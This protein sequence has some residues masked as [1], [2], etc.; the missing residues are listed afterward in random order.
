MYIASAV[1]MPTK[2]GALT[3]ST[4]PSA[5]SIPGTLSRAG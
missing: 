4:V 3:N 2:L 5:G 1:R